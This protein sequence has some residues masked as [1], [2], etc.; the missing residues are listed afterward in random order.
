M[1]KNPVAELNTYLSAR[2][3]WDVATRVTGKWK[4]DSYKMYCGV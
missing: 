3:E 2:E 4:G 1:D